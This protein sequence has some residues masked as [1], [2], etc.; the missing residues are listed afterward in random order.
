MNF[1]KSIV[2][3]TVQQKEIDLNHPLNN[4]SSNQG[5][6]TGVFISLNFKNEK[7]YKSPNN[8]YYILTCYHVIE[9]TLNIIV[10]VSKS[11]NLDKIKV[12]GVV[13]YIF[14]DDDLAVIEI[15]HPDIEC[16][17]LDYLIDKYYHFYYKG[18]ELGSKNFFNLLKKKK[19]FDFLILT[20]IIVKFNRI[21][22]ILN[23]LNCLKIKA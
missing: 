9:N 21:Q 3:I 16:N 20:F 15:E 17:I 22:F 7:N 11:N 19:T 14:P 23:T 8:K 2:Q 10:T 13:K 5:S 18:D 6:G 4:N 12:N 1:E